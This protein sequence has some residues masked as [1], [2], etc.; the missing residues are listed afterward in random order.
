MLIPAIDLK[1][2]RVVQLVQGE[3]EA[4]A[5][6]DVDA[7]VERFRGFPRVQVI[8][9]DAAKGTGD[10]RVLLARICRDLPCRVG[11]GL[12]SVDR[13]RQAL[14]AGA[15][16]VILGSALFSAPGINESFAAEVARACGV[17][18]VIGAVDARRGLV[19]VRGWQDSV[20][21]TPA[22]AV[23]RLEPWCGGFLYTHVDT[24]GLMGG[25]DMGAVRAVRAATTRPLTVAGGIRGWEEVRALEAL[26]ID[27]VVGMAVYSGAMA[28]VPPRRT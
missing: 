6:D 4:L 15:E 25:I 8:D 9:L 22:D 11:G 20:P 16:E 3:R 21:L 23:V 24:E 10:N 19:V 2:G 12:R 18:R 5:F 7:W 13:A 26:G 14:A 1:S 28:L 17:G 27:A